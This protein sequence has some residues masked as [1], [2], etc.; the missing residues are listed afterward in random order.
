MPFSKT[1]SPFEMYT[2]STIKRTLVIG[3]LHNIVIFIFMFGYRNLVS[4]FS[5]LIQVPIDF[6]YYY[7]QLIFSFFLTE[8]LTIGFTLYTLIGMS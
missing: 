7:Y 4:F 3:Y 1:W 6:Y 8:I 5:N 2:G